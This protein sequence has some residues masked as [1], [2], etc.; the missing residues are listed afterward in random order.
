[1][2]KIAPKLPQLIFGVLIIALTG[3][4]FLNSTE[5]PAKLRKRAMAITELPR[6]TTYENAELGFSL[7]YPNGWQPIDAGRVDASFAVA[8]S[9][10]AGDTVFFAVSVVDAPTDMTLQGA[11][12]ALYAYANRSFQNVTPISSGQTSLSGQPALTW[13]YSGTAEQ[14][15]IRCI[16]VFAIIG[17]RIYTVTYIAEPDS[18]DAHTPEYDRMLSSVQVVAQ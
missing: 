13:T 3:C 1:M 7:R 10:L 8:T 16:Q 9:S 18:F 5:K 2:G 17:R 11:G 15:E 6:E 4:P 14:T 12:D